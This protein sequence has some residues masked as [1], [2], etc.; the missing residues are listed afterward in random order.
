MRKILL[1]G[2]LNSVVKETS[3]FLSRY[4]HVQLCSE[5]AGVL[6]GM[7]KIVNPDL[8]LISLIGAYDIDTSIFYMLSSQYNKTPVLTI[9][10]KEESSTFFK[11]YED[12]QFENLI[13]PVE[14][15]AIMQAVC[16][17]LALDENEVKKDAQEE[18]KEQ[19]GKKRILVVDDNGTAL[20]TMKAMLEEY[21]EVALAISGAQAMTSIGKKRPDLILLDY[22]MPVCDGRMTLE[23]IRADEEMKDIPV[24]FLTA[25]NDRA[26]IE[27]VIKL[28][29]A[30]YFL[31]PPVKD[32]LLAEIEKILQ[33]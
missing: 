4:F 9:G 2:K 16:R 11:Y 8:V 7:M 33:K 32:K 12:G 27:A 25:I 24:V 15:T 19:T 3:Q 21:Y 14:N 10:T 31:K 18:K 26:N 23:M 29:P 17:R 30:G 5:N 20:R 13:R 28:K 1:I 22:E 6:E